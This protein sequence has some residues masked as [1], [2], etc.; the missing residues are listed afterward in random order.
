MQ[1]NKKTA[2]IFTFI[3][4]LILVISTFAAEPTRVLVLPFSINADKD[5]AY[6]K[7]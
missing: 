5:L 2:C 6:L 1:I 4:M 7:K 3:S